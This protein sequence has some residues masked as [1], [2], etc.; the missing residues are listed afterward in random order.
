ML[1]NGKAEGEKMTTLVVTVGNPSS[2]ILQRHARRFT[3]IASPT[4]SLWSRLKTSVHHR[5]VVLQASNPSKPLLKLPTSKQSASKKQK[6]ISEKP[7]NKG[8]AASKK[9]TEKPSK[10]SVNDQDV[11]EEVGW[12]RELNADNCR[13]HMKFASP[14]LP[15]C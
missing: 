6:T 11:W 13:A 8:K 12:G 3:V 4:S 14:F 10:A 2:S 1:V 15:S 9:Q 7:D 5:V